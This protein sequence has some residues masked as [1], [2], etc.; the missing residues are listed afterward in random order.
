MQPTMGLSKQT[1]KYFKGIVELRGLMVPF[2]VVFLL[3]TCLCQAAEAGAV[4]QN[5]VLFINSYSRD[6]LTVPVVVNNVEKEL[7]DIATIQYIFMNTKNLDRGFA[8]EQARRELEY[9]RSKNG[10]DF[11]MIITGDD[12]ALDFVRAYRNLYFKNMPVI[13]ENVNS[14]RKV[15]QALVDPM[16]AGVV[17]TFPLQ[18]TIAIALKL[19][20]KAKQV[21]VITDETISA[22]GTQ[23]QLDDIM[24]SFPQLT[25]T[26]LVTTKLTTEQ[27]REQIASY[28]EDT[29]LFFNMCSF[30]GSGKHYDI[31]S[32]I[33][34]VSEA[35]K[36]S[37]YKGDEAGLG[38]GLLGGC[39]LSYESVGKKTGTMARQVLTGEWTPQQ[40]G[41]VK[42]DYTYQFDFNVMKRFKINKSQLPKDTIY[43]NDPPSFYE[44][45]GDVLRPAA[46]V[47]LMT[48]IFLLLYDRDR[49]KRFAARLAQSQAEVKVAELSSKAKTDFLSRMSHDIRTPLNAIIG[50]TDLAEDDVNDP[51]KM[52]D[53]LQKIH[54]SGI[55]LLSLLNDVLDVSRI[56]SGNLT[57]HPVPY[58]LQEFLQDMHTVF[59]S[60]S[61]KL[62][63]TF[64]TMLDGENYT[65]LLDKV[66]FSQ[67][68]SNLIS[69]SLKFTPSGGTIN[70]IIQTEQAKAGRLPCTFF[71]TDTGKGIEKGF[72]KKMFEAFTQEQNV[73]DSKM[74]GSGL[75]LAIVQKITN[76]MKG[77]VAVHS[78]LGEGTTFTLSFSLEIA[79]GQEAKTSKTYVPV[80]ATSNDVLKGK[81]V[82]L[83]E[84]HPLNIEIAARMLYKV[85]IEV[86]KAENGKIAVRKFQ[87]EPRRYDLI[88]MDIRMPVMDGRQATKAIRM[89]NGYGKTV[90]IIAMTADA[91]D[92]DMKLSLE[93]GMNAQLNKPIEPAA[94]YA[95][96]R[97]Y[98]H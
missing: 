29:I 97:K 62:G 69:N 49:S 82:L 65:V 21:V 81:H 61:K 86:E 55:I 63:L 17:E 78:V 15:R 4:G 89:I 88:L 93:C 58:D 9:L 75:G 79:Q 39:M 98:L 20:P 71:V 90:P 73:A 66:R 32:G 16:M 48:I 35:A 51:V 37:L 80:L 96:L 33:N 13:F 60:Q 46:M 47:L 72:Q 44:L 8:V 77:S 5:R 52:K 23:E 19:T 41:Y 22:Q 42:G 2:F 85:G 30:D 87:A 40:L 74:G 6:Y 67:L 53:N 54:G 64:T 84:D 25:F 38:D 95:M 26:K 18:E 31:A 43:V 94:F 45:H 10:Y 68:I 83:V 1:K 92:G 57:L 3:F 59:D 14:E 34:F 36:V 7:K 50:L 56:E 11:D 70:L 12:D 76:L 27:L 24:E 28:G 91:F